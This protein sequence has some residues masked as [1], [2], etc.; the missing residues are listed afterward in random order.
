MA[1]IETTYSTQELTGLLGI[2]QQA[3]TKRAKREGWQALPRAGRGGG[4]LWVVSSMPAEIRDRLASALLR[5]PAAIT[6]ENTACASIGSN[7]CAPIGTAGNG[8]ALSDRER[9]IVTARLAFC[10][11]LDRI[12]PLVGKKAAVAHLGHVVPGWASCRPSSRNSW[13]W[14][15]PAAVVTADHAHALSLVCR[16]SGWRRGGPCAQAH[17][18]QGPR[19]GLRISFP[20][21]ETAAPHRGTGPCRAV[22]GHAPAR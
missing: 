17:G 11:E 10:R 8:P 16:L 9:A 4:K 3:I 1:A 6:E 18:S 7:I 20:L 21:P 15:L 12:A 19:V 5:Q 14:P 13:P 22:P 2:S